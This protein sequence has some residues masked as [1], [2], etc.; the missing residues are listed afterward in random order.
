MCHFVLY[1]VLL[2]IG[3]KWVDKFVASA[4]RFLIFLSDEPL[5]VNLVML[6]L[7]CQIS[8]V[9]LAYSGVQS[10]LILS[11]NQIG[12]RSCLCQALTCICLIWFLYW[13]GSFFIFFFRRAW[14]FI[15]SSFFLFIFI[16]VVLSFHILWRNLVWVSFEQS[17]LQLLSLLILDTSA[18]F[19]TQVEQ[20]DAIIDHS[21]LD[22]V[23]KRTIC[24]ERRHLIDFN[25]G[26]FE[27]VI[28]HDVEA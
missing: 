25:E 12:F 18:S 14:I 3:N 20:G 16:L 9:S 10:L 26:W 19:D 11:T 21:M 27:L 6:G 5:F 15:M 2:L 17:A 13:F 24:L 1:Y 7:H 22:L 28:D 8:Q 23:V 4:Q